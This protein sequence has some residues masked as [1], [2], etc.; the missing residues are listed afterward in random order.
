MLNYVCQKA[1]LPETTK[2]LIR[3]SKLQISTIDILLGQITRP[4]IS[5]KQP[6]FYTKQ[7]SCKACP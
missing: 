7:F 5:A 1:H 4:L 6:E 3:H 2:F